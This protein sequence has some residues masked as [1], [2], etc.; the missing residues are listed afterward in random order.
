MEW[1]TMKKLINKNNVYE[2]EEDTF[3]LLDVLKNTL[4][5]KKDLKVCE[6]GVGS[7]E[8]LSNLEKVYPENKYFGTDINSDAIELTNS[9]MDEANL[10]E[11]NLLEPF[12]ETFDVIY[13]NTPYLPCEDKE[14]FEDLSMKDK[15]IYG[16]K[17]GYEVIEEFILQIN[18]KLENNGE[19]YI[20]FSSLSNQEYIEKLLTFLCFE[21]KIVAKKK[22]SF[23]EL[24][25]MR[26]TKN[27][28]LKE[29]SF[30][31]VNQ[32]KYLD[33]GKHSKVLQGIYENNEVIIKIGLEQHL[34]KEALF[35]KK[36][37]KEKFIPR[38]DFAG[39]GYVV[40]EKLTGI[41]I[42]EWLEVSNAEDS[43]K[44][45]SNV[46][47]ICF[48]LDQLG[49]NKFEMTNPYKH[50][51]IDEKLNCKMI[52]FERCTFTQDPKNATQFLQYVRRNIPILKKKGL[53]F[54]DKKILAIAL[55]YKEDMAR[56]KVEDLL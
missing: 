56:F 19:V 34:D 28:L 41:K 9:R 38:F 1:I 8:I 32:I 7:G 43:L 46:F 37:E 45:L 11:G 51:F 47:D 20:L 23:E 29:I 6:V 31:D 3:L 52:D 15:A 48:R 12:K 42:R 53:K 4:K 50:I 10:V 44:I 14:K 5:Y 30:K 27:H 36:L 33:S 40:R 21:F 25:V 18:D 26:I 54:D 22:I 17:H 55:K 16:G 49:I 39:K 35:M 24:I 2:A 13:F